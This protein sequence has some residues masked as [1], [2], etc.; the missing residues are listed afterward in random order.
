MMYY[1]CGCYQGQKVTTCAKKRQPGM[2]LQS[3]IGFYI[4]QHVSSSETFRQS[5]I[6]CFQT[7]GVLQKHRLVF[8]SPAAAGRQSTGML[9]C[10]TSDTLV[11]KG[12][13]ALCVDPQSPAK[14]SKVSRS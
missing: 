13:L 10:F 1:L 5:D 7:S 8:V 9:R 14:R 6:N 12:C 2:F 11:K 4:V 3:G